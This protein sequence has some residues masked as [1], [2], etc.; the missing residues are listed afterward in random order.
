MNQNNQL[1]VLKKIDLCYRDVSGKYLYSPN[2]VHDRYVWLDQEAPYSIL[3]HDSEQ[4][5]VFM[6]ANHCALQCFKYC[7]EDILRLPSRLSASPSD[8]AERQKL[9]ESVAFEGIA[10]GYTGPRIDSMGQIF[11][12]YNGEIWQ[13]RDENNIVWGQA[14]LFW[15]YPKPAV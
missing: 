9:L 15:P 13:L 11:T 6:Y 10:T 8:R 4:D 12:I 2:G 3:A 5:P 1:N 7:R 14:A